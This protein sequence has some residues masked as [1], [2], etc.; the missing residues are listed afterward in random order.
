[1]PFNALRSGKKRKEEHP[2]ITNGT[3]KED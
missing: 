1:M 3:C 2:I